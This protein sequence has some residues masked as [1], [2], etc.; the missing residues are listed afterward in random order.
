MKEHR[1]VGAYTACRWNV[2]RVQDVIY[3]PEG[4]D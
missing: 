1:M 3:E 4:E 2:K